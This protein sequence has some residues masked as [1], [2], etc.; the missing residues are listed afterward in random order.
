MKLPLVDE[1]EVPRAKI[2]LY[3]LNPNHRSGKARFFR[4]HG[5]ATERWQELAAT[6]CAPTPAKTKWSNRKRRRWVCVWWWKVRWCC[7]TG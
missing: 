4:D 3:L 6:R 2:V 1:A 7:V 5:Y